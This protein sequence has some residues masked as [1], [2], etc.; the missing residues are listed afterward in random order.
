MKQCNFQCPAQVSIAAVVSW[1]AMS[2]V[3]KS[4]RSCLHS[5]PMEVWWEGLYLHQEKPICFVCFKCQ[6]WIQDKADSFLPRQWALT[7][8]NLLPTLEPAETR[9]TPWW[10]LDSAPHRKSNGMLRMEL[11]PNCKATCLLHSFLLSQDWGHPVS[12][13]IMVGSEKIAS[14]LSDVFEQKSHATFWIHTI[15]ILRIPQPDPAADTF[16]FRRKLWAEMVK[17]LRAFPSFSQLCIVLA[18]RENDWIPL[19]WKS[20]CL[21]FFPSRL[22]A[23]VSH[24]SWGSGQQRLKRM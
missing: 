11:G 3:I 24:Y 7:L 12:T 21:S 15:V 1:P 19:V 6:N 4:S 23:F 9:E 5:Q 22:P 16:D 14:P 17:I 8:E 13:G 2:K 20:Q 10:W 18:K